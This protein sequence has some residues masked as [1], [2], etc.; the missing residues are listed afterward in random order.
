MKRED[1]QTIFRVLDSD[2]SGEVSSCDSVCD[3]GVGASSN[4]GPALVVH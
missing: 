1:M 4:T 3:V 2:D